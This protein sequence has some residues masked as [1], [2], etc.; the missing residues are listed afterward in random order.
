MGVTGFQQTEIRSFEENG[1][2]IVLSTNQPFNLVTRQLLVCTNAF[3]KNLLPDLDIVPSRGQVLL[4]S[5]IERLM[6]KGTFHSDEGFYYFRNLGN[7]I[8]LGGAR[9]KALDEEST[10][11]DQYNRSHSVVHWKNTWM[12]LF[13]RVSKT[14]IPLKTGGQELWLWEVKNPRS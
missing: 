9:N 11:D 4:T 6:V 3:A 2:T 13:F 8:L 7:K 1:N 12:K 10:T 14:N 5:P